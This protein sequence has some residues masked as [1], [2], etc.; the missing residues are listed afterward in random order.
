MKSEWPL[1]HVAPSFLH[2]KKRDFGA[3][4]RKLC[5]SCSFM[6]SLAPWMIDILHEMYII[7][8][9]HVYA[10]CFCCLFRDRVRFLALLRVKIG[11]MFGLT[12]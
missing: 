11:L 5:I 3:G 9:A 10:W 2:V 8:M 6:K 7:S 12:F 4:G 1:R